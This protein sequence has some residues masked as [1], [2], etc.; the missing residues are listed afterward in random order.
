MKYQKAVFENLLLATMTSGI[1]Q[2]GPEYRLPESMAFEYGRLCYNQAIKDGI[3]Y[4]YEVGKRSGKIPI[5]AQ[6]AS[7][8]FADALQLLYLKDE[9]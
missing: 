5:P 1:K 4:M 2:K 7:Q 3:A 6:T 8:D 9:S